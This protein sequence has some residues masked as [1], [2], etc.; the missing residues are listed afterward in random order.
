LHKAGKATISSVLA[1]L[2]ILIWNYP[3]AS[4]NSNDCR[5]FPSLTPSRQVVSKS[6]A[7]DITAQAWQWYPSNNDAGN[8]GV[9][10]LGTKV[11]VVTANLRTAD[12]GIIH[13]PT[14][15][16]LDLRA[17]SVGLYGAAAT[18]NGDYFDQNGPWNSMIEGGKLSYA[19]PDLSGVVGIESVPV[20]KATG[21][22]AQGTLTLG[23]T[24][25]PITGV[26]QVSPGANSIV[27]YK[28]NYISPTTPT[29]D[30]T[31]L[32]VSGRVSKIYQKGM[33]VAT[34]AG[35]VVQVRGSWVSDLS[36]IALKTRASVNLGVTPRFE[37]KLAADSISS[38]ATMVGRNATLNFSAVN[39]GQTY[40]GS[41]NL[42]TDSYANV[43]Q[44]GRVT[45]RILSNSS[46]R[47]Y[48]A[49]VY[50]NGY[51]TSVDPGGFI[52]QANGPAATTALLFRAGDRVTINKT[53]SALNQSKF[54]SAS[55]RG[56]RLVE[57]GKLVWVCALHN[58]DFRPRS[59]IGWNQDGQVWFMTSSRGMDADDMGMRQ[60]GSSPDQMGHWLM[61]LGA[62]DAVLLDGGGSTTMEIQDPMVGWQRFDIP[63][64]SWYRPLANGF[65]ISPKK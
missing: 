23:T 62:T 15:K 30:L 12:F 22:R 5:S 2:S 31:L 56:P 59:A 42:Y 64:S 45:L 36:K 21:Y 8:A 16:T 13:P 57:N 34:S 44:A 29:G 4:A 20:N 46:G 26:N 53:F 19:T 48:V 27:V 11:S 37:T 1:V 47:Y 61:S 24:K 17:M 65:V 7:P 6:L 54:L 28:T 50:T 35:V 14:P 32:V 38:T 18:I 39:F 63:D 40:Y 43:T 60:G 49:N 55:G 41:A 52:V 9:S 3:P 10:P 58:L 51:N 25:Y 33:N